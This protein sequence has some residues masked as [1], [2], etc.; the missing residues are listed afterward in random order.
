[1]SAVSDEH[2]KRWTFAE[3]PYQR[4]A[5]AALARALGSGRLAHAYLFAGPRG[6]GKE[7]VA[8]ALGA[9]A[10]CREKPLEGCGAC[11]TCR[12]VFADVHPDF[13]RYEAPGMHF[14]IDRVREILAEAGR[15]PSESPRKVLLVVEPE[16]MTYRSDAPANAFLKTLEEPPGRTTTFVLVSHDPR[17]L[18]PT[19]VSRC[20]NV[21]FP[22]LTA[23]ELA[24][25]LVRE[26]GV[27]A[28]EA[29]DVARKADGTL[30]GAAAAVDEEQLGRLEAA[31]R[32][33]EELA[34][35]GV[36]EALGAAQITR[37]REEALALV[38]AWADLTHELAA[39]RGGAP[40][41]LRLE[42]LE[43]RVRALAGSGRLVTPEQAWEALARAAAALR[44]NSNVA[45]TLE[46]LFLELTA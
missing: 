3:L 32:I 35:G 41:T 45:L 28:A 31:L 8:Y 40:D 42:A 16:K 13:R 5:A 20:V 38:A 23:A 30:E 4:E 18:L 36:V 2:P 44:D 33:M 9:A 7:A 15:P 14:D 37:G 21:H 43:G 22:R 29:A 39:V 10:L 11:N 24:E 25:A 26:R 19:V 46:E 17:Q 34:A 12:R 27:P 6:V 1:M